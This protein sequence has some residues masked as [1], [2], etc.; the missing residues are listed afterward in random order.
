MS[1]ELPGPTLG[2]SLL[3]DVIDRG[4]VWLIMTKKKYLLLQSRDLLK[5]MDLKLLLIGRTTFQSKNTL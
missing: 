1:T 5:N 2:I 4:G 3:D